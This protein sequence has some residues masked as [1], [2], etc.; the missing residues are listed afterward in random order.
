MHKYKSAYFSIILIVIGL[1]IYLPTYID[2]NM[3]PVTKHS[4]YK[5]SDKANQL[6]QSL[7]I[8]DWHADSA[9][10]NRDLSKMNKYGHVDIPRLQKGNVAIQMFTTVTKSPS[11][12]NYE[13]NETDASDNITALAIVNRWPIKTWN[14]LTERAIFQANKIIKLSKDNPENFFLIKSQKD[15]N[16]FL[17]ARDMNE[18]LVGGL[19]GSEG[20]HALDGEIKNIQV[21]FDNGFRM[22][23][24]QHFFDNKL[25]GS[26]HGTTGMG[27]TSFGKDAVMEMIKLNIILDVSH[28][29]E[30]VVKDVLDITN[31]PIVISHTGFKGHCDTSRNISDSLMQEIAKRNGLIGIGYWDAAVCD[32]SPKSVAE[33]LHYGIALVGA[34]HLSLGSDFDGTIEPA[35]DT[36]ELSSITQ[37]LLN[38]GVSNE[39]ISK[40]MGLNML[41]FL[42]N[43]L[44][45]N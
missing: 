20:S 31:K 30:Q 45:K 4:P 9:L 14:S 27:L 41:N 5:I 24:L 7:L 33:A 25:G 36:S 26:L 10:W 39:D 8:G 12:Q 22:M 21:L 6:H 44:P 1:I 18:N 16:N 34:D 37:E 19:I 35:F 13:R 15:I 3:N 17:K 28:S 32:N 40:I 43:N 38:L 42:K 29:S 2:K 11:G 23:S